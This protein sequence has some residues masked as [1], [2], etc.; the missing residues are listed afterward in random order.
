M[1]SLSDVYGYLNKLFAFQDHAGVL[2]VASGVFG[3]VLG[4]LFDQPAELSAVTGVGILLVADL[5]TG[6]MAAVK[7]KTAVTSIALSRTLTKVFGYC[8]V[9][10]VAGVVERTIF[11]TIRAP[12]MVGCLWVMIATEGLSI[13]ENVRKCGVRGFG[14]LEN[15]L[16]GVRDHAK[17]A[18]PADAARLGGHSEQKPPSDS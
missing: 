8:S 17:T 4:Y 5:I 18:N 14:F 10:A 15:I 2:K 11:E 13:L 3:A 16:D 12:I 9:L 1:R 6:V 7:K